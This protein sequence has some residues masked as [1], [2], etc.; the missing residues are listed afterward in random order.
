MNGHRGCRV[1]L[2]LH[3]PHWVS[4][5]L[6]PILITIGFVSSVVNDVRKMRR[7]AS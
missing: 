2:P 5:Q 7:P 3:F 1:Q 4:Y 6:M